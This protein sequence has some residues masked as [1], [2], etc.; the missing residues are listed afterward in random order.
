MSQ[1]QRTSDTPDTTNPVIVIVGPTASGKTDVAVELARALEGE[2]VSAD[3]RQIYRFM[4]IATA[5]PSLAERRDIPHYGFDLVD[6]DVVFS[7][8]QFASAARDWINDI[9]ARGKTA[10]VAGGS[11]LY[12]QALI[13][14]FFAGD[15][16]KDEQVR[17]ELE[18][19][20]DRF[21]LDALHA[22]LTELD[23]E[24][25]AKILPTDRQR[26]LRAL[27]VVQA[28]GVRFSELHQRDRDEAAWP[29][30]WFGI[31]HDRKA[32]YARINRRARLML[33]LGL[34]AEVRDLIDRGFGDAYSMK[35]V[36]YEEGMAYLNGEIDSIEEML[37]RIQQN[38]R[39]YAK[40]QLTWFR[41]NE[42]IQWVR[43]GIQSATQIA[44]T[45]LSSLGR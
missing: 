6:P 23:P 18:E 42:R 29:V 12:L 2:V 41:R 40:R 37:E 39:R 14:G 32:L 36:G 17:R 7:A 15:D 26:I 13:D 31:E 11:G 43:A 30:R 44:D 10:I 22:E 34:L 28:S 38:T 3:S 27:E 9:R 4:D 24:Y 8:G 19:R 25:A 5:T 16:I 35:S 21:G 1:A 20:A 45:I 33:D